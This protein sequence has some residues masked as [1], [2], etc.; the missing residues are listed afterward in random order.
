MRYLALAADYDGTLARDGRVD[1]GTVAALERLRATSRKLI[2]VTG[3]VLDELLAIFP[4]VELFDLVV[5]ENGGVLFDPQ[6]RSTE[7]LAEA[8]PAR[9]VETLHARG[10]APV[11]VGRTIVATW[12]PNEVAV[13]EAIRDLGLELHVIF[14]KGAVMV[15]PTGITKAS[16]LAAALDR[17][18]LS[19]HNVVAV[20][21]AENDHSMLR[22]AEYGAAVANAVPLLKE[23]ADLV[24]ARDHGDGV[25]ELVDRLV[26][27][28]LAT[29]PALRR[30]ILLG[31]S[32]A[33]AEDVTM[34]PAGVNLLVAGSSGSGK[35]TLA[36]GVLERLA[37]QGYQFCIIDPEGDY[38]AFAEAIRLGGPDRA[39]GVN[40]ALTAM[41]KPSANVVVSL[42]GLPLND[43]PGFFATLLPRLQELRVQTGRPHWILVDETHHLLPVDWEAAPTVLTQELTGMIYVT[44][45]PGSV[46]RAV[47]ATVTT[48]ATLGEDPAATL[49]DFARA[50]GRAEP[51][52][53][54]EAPAAGEALLWLVDSGEPPF[55][56]RIAPS[57][58]DRTRHRRKYAEGSLPPDRSFYF[59]G[60]GKRLNLR[61]QNLVLFSQIADGVD[62]E[63]WLHHLRQGD[64]SAWMRVA[65][66]DQDLADEVRAIE[67]EAAGSAA[68]SRRRIRAAIADRYTLPAEGA[69]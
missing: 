8:P 19:P 43:R 59:R 37:A 53:T 61:A 34:P 52:V 24:L 29:H 44:V 1:D 66:K 57:E 6:A 25:A 9:F 62:D 35:S 46:S 38:D 17:L 58:S 51:H 67:A 54:G 28:D 16:G 36:T 14:N 12:M 41:E 22:F 42:V 68:E 47:L 5:A 45:H 33:R 21:D 18:R 4:R 26:D 27:D 65:I 69:V 11:A 63:T 13:L 48:V 64:Y 3:R 30:T 55:T 56:L 23:A 40:E 60:P 10:V 20:G 7:L 31:T 39:P 15:L 50:V 32:A 2:L 49:D